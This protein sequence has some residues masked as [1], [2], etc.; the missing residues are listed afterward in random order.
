MSESGRVCS[1][2]LKKGLGSPGTGVSGGRE[3][4]DVGAGHLTRVL[5]KISE[6]CLGPLTVLF[7]S[8]QEPRLQRNQESRLQEWQPLPPQED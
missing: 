5:C 8:P 6:P 4:P 7:P 3:L 1:R 2:K